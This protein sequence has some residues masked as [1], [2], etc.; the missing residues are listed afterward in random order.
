MRQSSAAAE[1]DNE[2]TKTIRGMYF[3]FPL[4]KLRREF[5]AEASGLRKA[6]YRAYSSAASAA[7]TGAPGR[8]FR[9]SRIS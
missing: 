1:E 6:I 4:P 8:Y 7:A 5:N 2:A 3:I 9:I